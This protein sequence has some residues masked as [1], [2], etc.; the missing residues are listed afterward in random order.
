MLLSRADKALYQSKTDGRNK[1]TVAEGVDNP[2]E[3]KLKAVS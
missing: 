1:I 3:P 2:D